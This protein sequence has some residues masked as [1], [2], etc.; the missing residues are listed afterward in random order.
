M[1]PIKEVKVTFK[2]IF[3][4]EPVSQTAIDNLRKKDMVM[5]LNPTIY[6]VSKDTEIEEESNEANGS[7]Q[8]NNKVK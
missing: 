7:R 4:A 3:S 8:T 5:V 6:T 1:A 2:T